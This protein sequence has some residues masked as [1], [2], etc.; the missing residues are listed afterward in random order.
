MPFLLTA[1]LA[2]GASTL[3]Q[4]FGLA[5]AYVSLAFGV[6]FFGFAARY[7]VATV[8]VLLAP[9]VSQV[10]G[11]NGTNGSNGNGNGSVGTPMV[12]VHLALYNEERVVDRLLTACTSFDYPNYEVIVVDDSR[13]G[14][15]GRLKDWIMKGLS[16]GDDRL[17]IYHR[18]NRKGF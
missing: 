3:G 12:S 10:N 11:K 9:S 2:I 13:D 5:L 7:Y 16:S 17:K 4:Y 1:G 6:L 14:T 15:V 18:D 8:S